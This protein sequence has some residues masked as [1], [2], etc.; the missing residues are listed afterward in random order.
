[1]ASFDSKDLQAKQVKKC[2]PLSPQALA[3]LAR[4]ICSTETTLAF[5][6]IFRKNKA[7]RPGHKETLVG[8]ACAGQS[9]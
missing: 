2:T 5:L 3:G 7:R 1:L 8:R 9:V 4:I 6:L